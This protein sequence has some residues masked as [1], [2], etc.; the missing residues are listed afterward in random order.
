M[1]KRIKECNRLLF[2]FSKII[3]FT[4]Y[5]DGKFK[6]WKRKH[7]DKKNIFRLKKELNYTA[8]KAIRN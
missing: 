3:F 4:A 1:K 6:S 2:S 8:I 7:K 5:N